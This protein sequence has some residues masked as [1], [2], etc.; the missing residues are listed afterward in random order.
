MKKLA[1]V[2]EGGRRIAYRK[3]EMIVIHYSGL[4]SS[5]RFENHYDVVEF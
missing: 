1:V 2:P 3:Q 4:L 5:V